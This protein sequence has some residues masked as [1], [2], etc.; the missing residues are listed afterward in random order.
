MSEFVQTG[1]PCPKCG[2][3]DAVAVNDDGWSTCFS[4]KARWSPGAERLRDHN[5][6]GQEAVLSTSETRGLVEDI[7][8]A[9]L[10]DRG[11]TRETVTRYGYGLARLNGATVQVAPY[12]DDSGRIVAQKIRYPGKKFEVRGS[13]KDARLFGEHLWPGKG[14]MVVVTE[15]ELD[16]MAAYQAQG[17]RWATVSLPSGAAG[18]EKAIRKSLDW[19]CGFERVVLAFDM[20]EPGQAAAVKA[21]QVLPPGKAYIARLPAKDACECLKQAK[22]AELKSAFWDARPWRPD[23][24]LDGAEAWEK[25]VAQDDVPALPW[26][27]PLLDQMTKGIRPGEVVVVTGGTGSGKTTLVQ[28]LVVDQLGNGTRVGL[29]SLESPLRRVVLDLSSIAMRRPRTDDLSESGVEAMWEAISEGLSLYNHFGSTGSENILSRMR[30]M[31]RALGCKVLVL[32]HLSIVVSG[33]GADEDERRTLDRVMTQLATLAQE[34][35]AAII[36]VCHLRRPREGA[37]EEGGRVTLSDLRSSGSIAQLAHTV[38]A[39]E[40]DQ[41][42]GDKD[43]T[44]RVLKCRH[45]G[46]LG[47]AD[48]VKYDP[49]KSRLVSPDAAGYGL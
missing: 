27:L 23:G 39:V 25:A 18:A 7:R 26:G 42:S 48:V 16:A 45:T 8:V 41:Q 14:R 40:R 9:P 6:G 22:S 17:S 49:E 2:S 19:L 34:V 46:C 38:V 44:L 15:G 35:E 13:L 32:D 30:Y 20:D 28:Q 1:L 29:L 37:H 10:G 3:S 12:H 36:V 21:A 4:C 11:I 43:A 33:F 24:I 47:P 5:L 31:A